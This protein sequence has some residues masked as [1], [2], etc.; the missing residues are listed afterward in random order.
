MRNKAS[1]LVDIHIIF[2]RS[3]AAVADAEIKLRAGGAIKKHRGQ[4][5][6]TK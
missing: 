2:S 1:W 4:Y 3:S 5:E 6:Q